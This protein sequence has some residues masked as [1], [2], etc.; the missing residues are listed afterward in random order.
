MAKVIV[1]TEA[2]IPLERVPRRFGFLE[3]PDCSYLVNFLG[4]KELFPFHP[5]FPENLNTGRIRLVV[6]KRRQNRDFHKSG[7]CISKYS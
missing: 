6:K 4:G 2:V 1:N 5:T 3:Y 7:Y